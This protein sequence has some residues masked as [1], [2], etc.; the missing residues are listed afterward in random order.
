[1]TEL[2][3]L[4]SLAESID[5]FLVS[6]E[7]KSMAPKIEEVQEQDSLLRDSLFVRA[8]KLVSKMHDVDPIT[9]K[10]RY[11]KI[12]CDKVLILNKKVA[13]L[14]ERMGK[15][16]SVA[17][18]SAPTSST[19]D[20]LGDP[21]CVSFNDDSADI[22]SLNSTFTYNHRLN[23]VESTL[24]QAK[25]GQVDINLDLLKDEKQALQD[26]IAK[27]HERA[28]ATSF[29]QRFDEM[30]ARCSADGQELFL[31][32]HGFLKSVITNIC[33]RPEDENLRRIRVCH[34]VVFSKINKL[35][36]GLDLILAMGFRVTTVPLESDRPEEVQTFVD[37]YSEYSTTP[38]EKGSSYEKALATLLHLS[39]LLSQEVLLTMVE[40]SVEDVGTWGEWWDNLTFI[41]S[42]ICS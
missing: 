13:G 8:D 26:L 11:G 24:M 6:I 28:S 30:N 19:K 25:E 27:F 22:F 42:I 2:K 29:Q 10:P 20:N 33:S 34:P 38:C 15:I 36:M 9:N 5:L 7:G 12:H 3:K 1:M 4:S 17:E 35:D 39:E 32:L 40:P 21:P 14:I 18:S 31:P 41:R 23:N 37:K 16:C